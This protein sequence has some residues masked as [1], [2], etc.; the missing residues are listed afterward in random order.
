LPGCFLFDRQP[1]KAGL[2]ICAFGISLQRH[3]VRISL[4]E[5]KEA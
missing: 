5:A 4:T 2:Q 3:P 1:S